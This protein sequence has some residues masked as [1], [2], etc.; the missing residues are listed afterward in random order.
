MKANLYLNAELLK[1]NFE[2]Q[3]FSEIFFNDF[4]KYLSKDNNVRLLNKKFEYVPNTKVNSIRKDDNEAIYNI[5]YTIDEF[6][7]RFC[8]SNKNAK[9]TYVFMGC[10]MVF[11][12]GL[13]D[14][15]T[16]PYYFSKILNFNS[17]VINIGYPEGAIYLKINKLNLIQFF[18]FF[19]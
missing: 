12:I 5:I 16:L 15:E 4:Y 17:N 9:V 6:G 8:K 7:N 10:S 19:F 3:S 14:D 18:S 1:G 11:G 13:E 2:K